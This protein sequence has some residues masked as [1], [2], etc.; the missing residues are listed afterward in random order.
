M[1]IS[2]T[3]WGTLIALGSVFAAIAVVI[4]AV[5]NFK[6]SEARDRERAQA[7]SEKALSMLKD[8][9]EHNVEHLNEI[10]EAIGRERMPVYSFETAAWD[11]VSSGGLLVQVE[12][13]TLRKLTD[14]YYLIRLSNEHQ[15]Q[16][17]YPEPPAKSAWPQGWK[18]EQTRA[19]GDVLKR[20]EPKL[21]DLVT[22]LR[23]SH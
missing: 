16:L 21:S 17:G 11:I 23:K 19:I 15:S 18:T 2:S 12:T 9:C 1:N 20:L 13:E 6:F 7:A 8:E 10:R 5:G 22:D 3:T 14:I 4:A